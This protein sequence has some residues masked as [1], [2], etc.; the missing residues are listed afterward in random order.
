MSHSNTVYVRSGIRQGRILSP[1]LFIIFINL[2]IVCLR[3]AHTGCVINRTYLGCCM[4]ANDL[5]I[6]YASLSGLIVMLMNCVHTFIQLSLSLNANKSNADV[7]DL[8]LGNDKITWNSS[9]KYLGIHFVNGKSIGVNI[10]P[11]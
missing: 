10:E 11:Y 9:F 8:I 3:K 4:Y 1:S 7:H 6:L 2:I 5:I